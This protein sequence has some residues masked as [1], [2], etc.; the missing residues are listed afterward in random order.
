MFF[1]DSNRENS[2]FSRTTREKK[3]AFFPWWK[4]KKNFTTAIDD[5]S[6]FSSEILLDIKWGLRTENVQFSN[7]LIRSVLFEWPSRDIEDHHRSIDLNIELNQSNRN[8]IVRRHRREKKTYNDS[9]LMFL[10][11]WST[12]LAKIN[13]LDDHHRYFSPFQTRTVVLQFLFFSN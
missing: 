3:K 7:S 11:C 5:E 6:S 4:S 13:S 10:H 8:F 2:T 1:E 9:S 12:F